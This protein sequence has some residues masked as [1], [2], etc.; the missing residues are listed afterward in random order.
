VKT[1][2]FPFEKGSPVVALTLVHPDPT[3]TPLVECRETFA[4]DTGFSDYLQVDWDT[5]LALDLQHHSIGTLTSQL[6]DGS[7]V[8]DYV[9]LIGVAI[10]E[11]GSE[12]TLRCL[13]NPAYGNDLLLVGGRFLT[14]YLA[15]IDYAQGLTSLSA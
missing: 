6:A 10:P 9:A 7:T 3:A 2:A 5:F 8:T 15:Q 1:H 13:S 12:E 4:V 11:C 14:Q